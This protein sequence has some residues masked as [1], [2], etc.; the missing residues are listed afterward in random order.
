MNVLE[1]SK[2]LI[3]C[4]SVTPKEAGTLKIIEQ[5]FSKY[6]CNIKWINYEKV[7][8]LF[9]THGTD[10]PVF[11]FLGHID[12]VPA[13]PLE[14]WDAP[15]FVPTIKDGMLYGRGAADMKASVA[16][17]SIA[18]QRFIQSSPDHHGTIALLL[19]SDEEGPAQ[20][21][22]KRVVETFFRDTNQ[23]IN[24]CL[25]GEPTAQKNYG[26]Q[27]KNG[28]RGSITAKLSILGEQGHVAFPDL[29]S[30]AI[31]HANRIVTRLIQ[32]QWDKG[33]DDFPPTSMQISNIQAGTGADN[34]IPGACL[35]V[36]NLRYSTETN[37]QK[38]K[39][40]VIEMLHD[41]DY[42]INWSEPSL[43]FLTKKGVFLDT[44]LKVV[45]EKTGKHASISTAG[46]T[47]D[48]RF[49]APMGADVI[50]LGPSNSTIHKVNECVALEDLDKMVEVY[51]AI[52]QRMLS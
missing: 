18:M 32:H 7:S 46:G 43:P 39:K 29:A 1:L 19:T 11:L 35:I 50:E 14:Q 28:R 21:G 42:H 41:V 3:A 8:N 47:S 6:S 27:I 26:D 33:N 5:Y 38:I 49:I 23:N 48:G 45:Q 20:D 13:G 17:M 34:V 37:P 36:F 40:Q 22:V 51:Q 25:V 4:Q 15:P 2:Q 16:A 24:W 31:H 9:I 12:V 52:A 30:N 44:V 10:R